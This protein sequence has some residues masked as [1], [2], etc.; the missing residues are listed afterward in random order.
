MLKD[1]PIL[2]LDEATA[3]TDRKM[4]YGF[5]QSSSFDWGWTLIVVRPRLSTIMS[6]Q[7]S[8]VNDGRIEARVKW[9][10]ADIRYASMW[11]AI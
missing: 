8:L 5:G 6:V 2:I 10:I 7:M 4:A 11:Q 1:A 3:Y 9:R